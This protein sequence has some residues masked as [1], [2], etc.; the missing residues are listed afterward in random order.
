MSL[1][2][3][4][5]D[6]HHCNSPQVVEEDQYFMD[7]TKAQVFAPVRLLDMHPLDMKKTATSYSL[8]ALILQSRVQNPAGLPIRFAKK[9][10]L[11]PAALLILRLPSRRRWDLAFSEYFHAIVPQLRH[12]YH[13]FCRPRPSLYFSVQA[14]K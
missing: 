13:L 12:Y 3:D 6:L 4:M 10:M 11:D 1:S 9:G 5:P 14:E 8:G 2:F 7:Q